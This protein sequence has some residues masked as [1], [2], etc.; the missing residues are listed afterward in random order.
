MLP[1]GAP[2]AGAHAAAPGGG[3]TYF[4]LSELMAEMHAT[5]SPAEVAGAPVQV[6]LLKI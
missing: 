1:L 6:A 5:F 3:A 4:T 2:P